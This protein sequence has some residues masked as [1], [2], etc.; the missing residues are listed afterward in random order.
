MMVNPVTGTTRFQV[1]HIESN[2]FFAIDRMQ[3]GEVSSPMAMLTEDGNQAFR[4]VRL[5]QRTEP[6]SAS[7]LTDYDF[8]QEMALENKRRKAVIDWVN[9]NLP[10]TFVYIHENYR[11][12]DYDVDW[13]GNR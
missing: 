9:R 8:I 6:R 2:L 4:I 3:V 5:V 1:A 7:L 12:C 11:Y 10:G 13:L